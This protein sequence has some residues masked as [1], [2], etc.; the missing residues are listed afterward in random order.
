MVAQGLRKETWQGTSVKFLNLEST[1][2]AVVWPH[3]PYYHVMRQN[4]CCVVQQVA[5]LHNTDIIARVIAVVVV[6]YKDESE[7]NAQ[8]DVHAQRIRIIYRA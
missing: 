4:G 5:C 8:T 7:C 1:S 6:Y 2:A 3:L